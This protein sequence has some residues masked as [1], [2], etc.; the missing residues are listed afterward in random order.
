M[1]EGDQESHEAFDGVAAE[2]AGEHGGDFGL[3][4]AENRGGGGLG[5]AARAD[6]AIDAEDESG[7][8]DVFGGIGEAEVGEYVAAAGVVVEWGFI[9]HFSPR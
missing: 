3:I 7:F 1:A 5:E 6:G 4:D 2:V 9:R 8:E